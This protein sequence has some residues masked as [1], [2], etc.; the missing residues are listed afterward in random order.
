MACVR[1]A[2]KE[3]GVGVRA[4]GWERGSAW[5]CVGEGG[6]GCKGAYLLEPGAKLA[7]VLT[8]ALL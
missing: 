7:L 2:G 6:C 4:C 1:G 8:L 3:W 5:E